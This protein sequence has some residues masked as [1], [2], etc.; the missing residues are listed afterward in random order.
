MRNLVPLLI[1][2]ILGQIFK[3]EM[4]RLTDVIYKSGI[5]PAY[6]SVKRAINRK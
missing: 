1:G 2:V 3:E 4:N 5:K 6:A